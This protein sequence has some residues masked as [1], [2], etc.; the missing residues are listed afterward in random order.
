MKCA[1]VERHL[2]EALDGGNFALKESVREHLESCAYCRS[3]WRQLQAADEQ[4]RLALRQSAHSPE[5]LHGRIVQAL[6]QEKPAAV[7]PRPLPLSRVAMAAAAGLMVALLT[8]K[9]MHLDDYAAELGADA[10][11]AYTPAPVSLEV[12]SAPLKLFVEEHKFT[13][14]QAIR[15]PQ[16]DFS[17]LANSIL[18]V[19]REFVNWGETQARNPNES[20]A[21]P[22]I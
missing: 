8:M 18:F 6:C 3:E 2:D 10:D 1:E 5:Q 22:S 9:L 7:R 12:S 14:E 13:L 11:S 21:T 17:E 4:L 15:Q 16:K 20:I 19:P